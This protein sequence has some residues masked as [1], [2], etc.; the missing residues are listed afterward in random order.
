MCVQLCMQSVQH[1]R[2]RHLR[3]SRPLLIYTWIVI[4]PHIISS[5][6]PGCIISQSATVPPAGAV[7]PAYRGLIGPQP[8]AAAASHFS[9]T[10]SR[11]PAMR[12]LSV[13]LSFFFG[14]RGLY[15]TIQAA[16]AQSSAIGPYCDTGLLPRGPAAT[17]AAPQPR[18]GQHRRLLLTSSA[19]RCGQHRRLLFTSSA[20]RRARH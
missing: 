3:E 1:S 14:L 7:R 6:D 2:R 9:T 8:I 4:M 16:A 18:C 5:S 17:W 19:R 10:S 20:R 11:R 15:L 12:L 13:F